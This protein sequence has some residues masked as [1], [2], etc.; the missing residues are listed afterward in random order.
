MFS[1]FAAQANQNALFFF[2]SLKWGEGTSNFSFVLTEIV[3]SLSLIRPPQKKK[4]V[5]MQSTVHV[6]LVV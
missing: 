4:E 6:Q 3:E 1:P 2:S 5:C